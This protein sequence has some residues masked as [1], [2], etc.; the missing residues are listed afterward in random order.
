MIKNLFG[1]SV[2]T[3]ESI[4][5][6]KGPWIA[7]DIMQELAKVA[8]S[9][10]VAAFFDNQVKLGRFNAGTFIFADG[11]DLDIEYLQELRLFNEEQELYFKRSSVGFKLR[12]IEDNKGEA[13]V[14]CVDTCA[15]F[16][17]DKVDS[18]LASG[19]AKLWE[20]GRK[21]GLVIPVDEDAKHYALKTRTY[22]TYDEQ[23]GQAGFCYYRYVD[24]VRA[25]RG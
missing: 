10:K 21:I 19:F 12:R 13:E 25:E 17:G 24:V 5:S 15:N 16:F 8:G 6:V 7:V 1:K 11:L 20:E 23:T 18:G 3:S 14:E 9:F 22:I 2:L 4:C